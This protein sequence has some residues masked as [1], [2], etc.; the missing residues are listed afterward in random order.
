[1]AGQVLATGYVQIVP[2][3]RGV[4][5]AIIDTFDTTATRAGALGGRK[6]ASGMRR[7]ITAR[8]GAIMGA[9]SAIASKAVNVITNSLGGA[10]KRADIMANFPR[11]MRN[12]GAS[13]RESSAAI[14]QMSDHLDGLP[15]SLP[16]LA[17]MVQQLS[18]VTSGIKEATSVAEAFNDALLAG[19][20]STQVQENAMEQWTQML[21]AG[22]PDMMAWRSVVNAMPGQMNQLARSM[23]GPT[24]NSLDLYEAVKSGTVSFQD[25]N[26]A[27]VRLDTQGGRGF[28]SF[29]Q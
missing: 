2:S 3:M 13:T 10:V 22:K 23:L 29:S 26:R 7:G 21:A 9:V 11:V 24:K 15:T 5:K 19:G 12:F 4:G 6:A 16:A 1:M 27:F 28:A 8:A 17:G 14:K 18:P 20:G 25:L